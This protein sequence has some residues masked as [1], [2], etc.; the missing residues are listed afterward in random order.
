MLSFFNDYVRM[1][2]WKKLN[3]LK[4]T[5]HK[6]LLLFL[7][8]GEGL[9][10]VVILVKHLVVV[11]EGVEKLVESEVGVASGGVASGEWHRG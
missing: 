8:G 10:V 5:V 9:L 6:R 2:T 11:K 1:K 3:K 4:N 7:G